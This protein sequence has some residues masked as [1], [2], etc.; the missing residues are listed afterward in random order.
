MDLPS[1][2]DLFRV[3]A[4]ELLD[5]NEDVMLSAVLEDGSDANLIAN[6]IS[7]MG[8]EL[9][10][11]LAGV[12]GNN[13]LDT[14]QG[15]ALVRR[16]YDRHQ[17]LPRPAAAAFVDLTFT[18]TAPNPTAFTIT[19]GTR[20]RSADGKQYETIVD[21]VFAI[22]ASS[23]TGV[24]ARAQTAGRASM[25][26]AGKLT[27]LVSTVAGAPAGM[28]VTNPAASAGGME[29]ESP[30]DYRRR[31]RLEPRSRAK[32]T[33]GALESGALAVPGVVRATPFEGLDAN[34]RAN[35]IVTV[36]IADEYTDALVRQGVA[37]PAYESQSQAF[38]RV[39]ERAFDEVRAF[40]IHVGCYVAQV[41]LVSYLLRLRFRAG[42]DTEQATVQ[43]M[44]A[45][46]RY[47]NALK[48][49]ASVE[50]TAIVTALRAISGLDV[51]GDEVADPVGPVIPISPYQVLRTNLS[52]IQFT[53]AP[54]T[55]GVQISV[56]P[57][58]FSL[59]L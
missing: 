21:T 28:T 56:T 2:E 34:G 32:A 47:T 30:D 53:S 22:A 23:V 1:R 45:V 39:V 27:S 42:A 9:V 25:V 4:A 16:G 55:T 26:S 17:I 18:L 37:V 5:A 33:R 8:E 11:Q 59:P 36:A 24:R 35:R 44:A 29:A 54:A 19:A 43:A 3:V 49:G 51:R 20:V 10:S 50:P 41:A 15:Q 7:A 13:Y 31:C 58:T 6:A 57:G 48:P 38:G 52:L 14:A 12:Q 46:V 40:G